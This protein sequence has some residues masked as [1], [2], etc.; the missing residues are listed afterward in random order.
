MGLLLVTPVH[1]RMKELQSPPQIY[2]LYQQPCNPLVTN[3]VGGLAA[4]LLRALIISLI[5]A[6]QTDEELHL[7]PHDPHNAWVLVQKEARK[8]GDR[9]MLWAFPVITDPEQEPWWEAISC[10]IL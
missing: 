4:T 2:P 8:D 10:S 9:D 6:R 3:T 5:L 7:F 1:P